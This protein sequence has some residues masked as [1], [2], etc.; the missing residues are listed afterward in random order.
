MES[1]TELQDARLTEMWGEL[2]R[3]TTN[4]DPFKP[5]A[6]RLAFIDPEILQRRETRGIR[7][8]L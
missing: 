6:Y 2:H 1:N 3:N 8:Q 7:F 5:N 4:G